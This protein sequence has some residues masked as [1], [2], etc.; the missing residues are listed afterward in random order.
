MRNRDIFSDSF[1]YERRVQG[2]T[3]GELADKAGLTL[4]YLSKLLK[5]D[6]NWNVKTITMVSKALDMDIEFKSHYRGKPAN[7]V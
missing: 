7:V 4:S 6:R 5:G 2:L 3:I 1:D